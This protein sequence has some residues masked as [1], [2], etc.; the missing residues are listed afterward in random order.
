[1]DRKASRQ[2]LS[3]RNPQGLSCAV[4][5][6]GAAHGHPAKEGGIVA[7]ATGQAGSLTVSRRAT[8]DLQWQWQPHWRE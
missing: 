3:V 8:G 4:T 2:A 6:V 5:T 7:P 1:M